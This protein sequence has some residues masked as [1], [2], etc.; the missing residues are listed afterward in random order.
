ML[1]LAAELSTLA[2]DPT[3]LGRRYQLSASLPAVGGAPGPRAARGQRRRAALGGE[4]RRRLLARRDHLRDRLPRRPHAVRGRRRWPKARH[5]RG[6]HR[7]RSVA[8]SPSC[9]D[10]ASARPSR[11][12]SPPAANCACGSAGIVSSLE[13]DG[14]IAYVPARALLR[15]RT[16]RARAA[17]RDRRPRREHDGASPPSCDG[18]GA[19]VTASTGVAGGGAALVDALRGLLLP[20]A[21][22]D[23]LVCLYMLTQ[24][25]ALTAGERRRR[26]R[27]CAPAAPARPPIRGLLAGRGAR[28]ARA[29]RG[30]RASLLER[31]VLGPAVSRLAAG[32]RD[33][34]ARR[35]RR[36][37]RG[38]ARSG[39]PRSARSPSGG[40]RAGRLAADRR[41][42]AG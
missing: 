3:A 35:R 10:C 19:E 37:D 8:A 15:R 33:A 29:R 6:D 40:W 27:C 13:H 16:R 32:L 2:N 18:L 4:R 24:A 23:G 26:S 22:V 30:G 39:S 28:R 20:I 38:P 14:R 5:L 7:R 41:G 1:A 31:L 34:A 17:R 42:A 25:L 21:A 36:R 12:R 11:W 9:S